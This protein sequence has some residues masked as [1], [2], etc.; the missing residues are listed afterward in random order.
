MS[1]DLLSAGIHLEQPPGCDSFGSESHLEQER[2]CRRLRM[3]GIDCRG[4]RLSFLLGIDRIVLDQE[5]VYL[6]WPGNRRKNGF[7]HK[8]VDE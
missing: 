7:K 6:P 1:G 4:P 8:G 3:R 2:S 5:M